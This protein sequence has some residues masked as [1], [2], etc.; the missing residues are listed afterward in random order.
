MDDLRFSHLHVHTDAS[1]K[2]GLGSVSRLVKYAASVGYDALAMTD[3]G[4]LANAVSFSLECKANG[5]KPIL[6]LEG[7]LAQGDLIGHITLLAD[8][9]RGWENLVKLNNLGHAS[10]YKHP[11]FTVE[12]LMEY[13]EDVVCLTGCQ[14]SLLH[15]LDDRSAIELGRS[16][17]FAFGER[18]FVEIMFIGDVD[19]WTRSVELSRALRLPIVMTNDS[20]FP[21]KA[22]AKL[23]PILTKMKAGF[24]Y[25]SDELWLKTPE[26]MFYRARKVS[27]YPTE[28]IYKWMNNAHRIAHKLR[29]VDLAKPQTLPLVENADEKLLTLTATGLDTRGISSLERTEY[30]R[31]NRRRLY[32]LDIIKKMGYSTYFLIVHDLVNWARKNNVEVG[33]G[34]GSGAGSLVLYLI[35]VTQVDPL[36]YNLSFERF[37]NPE[38]KGMPDVDLDFESERRELVLDYAKEKYN[39]IP[40]ATYSRYNHKSLVHDLAKMFRVN[41]ALEI[42]AAEM[43]PDSDAFNKV[44]EAHEGFSEAYEAMLT[45]IRHKGKHAG[46]VIITNNIVPVERASGKLV[47][48]WTEGMNNELS[49]AGIVKFDLLGLSALSV[50]R[51]VREKAK[52][53]TPALVKIM[54]DPKVFEVFR[55]GDLSGIFQFSGSPGIRKLTVDLQPDVFT[56]LIAINAL[57]RP[58]AL[59]AGTAMNYPKYKYSPRRVPEIFEPILRETYGVVVYQEQF[60]Q[61]IQVVLGGSL[62][63]AD[64]ARRIITKGGK[65]TDDPKHMAELATLKK[66]FVDGCMAKGL[67]SVQANDWWG[68]LETHG[69]YSFN[70]SHSTAYSMIA[71]QTAAWKYHHPALFYAESLNVDSEQEQNYIAA[72]LDE[73]IEVALPNVNYS[74]T[75][76]TVAE[77]KLYM[78]LSAI[79]FMG[80]TG[81]ETIVR[82][83]E[84]LA[85][86]K[87]ESMKQFMELN[88][89]KLVRGRGREGLW[90]LGG[91]AGT[92]GD[93]KDLQFDKKKSKPET[94]TLVEVMKT[95]LGVIIPPPTIMKTM[96][97]YRSMGW[98]CGII[99][100]V[101]P[102]TSRYGPY[103]T[104]YLSPSGMFWVRGKDTDLE[105]GMIVA[106]KVNKT[107]KATDVDKLLV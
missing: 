73:G 54:G 70:K 43:G 47:A 74:G 5:I 57:F 28:E 40:I 100:K 86:K 64:L 72:A 71:W 3:H 7:Y 90:Y 27:H 24:E 60:M 8:G 58:G 17:K 65:K 101:V 22:D 63:Q 61:M 99:E 16:L 29:E 6:G 37:L 83:R 10:V 68:E 59:D 42:E 15:K 51:R 26:E 4:S 80:M 31:Y 85:T 88:P 11:A 84:R 12:Q 89:K 2:D 79:K 87:Y 97:R 67:T 53:S 14:A 48:A 106:A 45:Q 55:K 76:W 18:L 36:E 20:H 69:R 104:V 46:G 107:N 96:K 98:I 21:Y 50:L 39:A 95:F 25:N 52:L 19:T 33:A 34:R 66:S 62:G 44:L 35:G 38:R 9:E 56:D 41:Q 77:G 82:N 75:E 94:Y 93:W 103:N 30:H 23:H 78:P 49:Y 1:L 81:A 32:E 91:F 102:K 92:P 105:P 13:S